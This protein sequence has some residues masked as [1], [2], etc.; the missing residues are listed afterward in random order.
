L[1]LQGR[2]NEAMQALAEAVDAGFVSSRAYDFWSFDEDPI[3]EPLRSDARFAA[4]RQRINDRLEEM[5]Q[6]V[7]LAKASG[8]WG[9]LLAKAGSA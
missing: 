5:R 9:A 8:D 2:R 7:E 4:L 6:H 3:I 1:T